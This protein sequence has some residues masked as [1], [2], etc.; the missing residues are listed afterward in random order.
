MNICLSISFL[1]SFFLRARCVFHPW[2]LISLGDT[3]VTVEYDEALFSVNFY[4]RDARKFTLSL[5]SSLCSTSISEISSSSVGGADGIIVSRG[6]CGVREH[7]QH[8]HDQGYKY[9]LLLD[10]VDRDPLTPPLGVK[11][12]DIHTTR[13]SVAAGQAAVRPGP[14]P[15]VEICAGVSLRRSI[16]EAAQE[17]RRAAGGGG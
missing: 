13:V 4:Q 17:H 16:G 14:S 5:H 7:A 3:G 2:G 6:D 8:A 15:T 10:D 9:A 11:M 1:L 12:L